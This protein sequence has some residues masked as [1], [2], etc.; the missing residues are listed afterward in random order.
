KL[1]DDR[2]LSWWAVRRVSEYSGRVNLW[3]AGSFGCLFAIYTVAG[4]HWPSWLGRQVF[5]IFEQKMGGVPGLA[6]ALVVLSAVPAAFQYGLW[7]S[8]TQDRCRRLE[9][10]LMTELGPDD[11][12]SAA[13]AAAW[14]RG[15]G[16]FFVALILWLAAAL[17][18]KIDWPQAL[19]GVAA[20]VVLWGLYFALGFWAFSRGIQANKLG[21][22]LTVGL[23]LAAYCLV[24]LGWPG[25]S[26]L[27]P[28]GSVYYAA[29]VAPPWT[30][31]IGASAGAIFMLV[32]ARW[33]MR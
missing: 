28:P 27:L 18:G 19:A 23:P 6:T 3:L 1:N 2:P 8:N 32:M 15:W 17:A 12:W 29:T 13:A 24:K 9:L 31:S 25:L 7:D 11:Y 4:D 10:L 22:L 21:L 16:Y 5:V 33:A 20:G 26:G 14:K 30:W